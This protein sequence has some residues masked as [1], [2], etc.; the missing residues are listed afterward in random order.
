MKQ[1]TA[2]ETRHISIIGLVLIMLLPLLPTKAGNV[3]D[4][5]LPLAVRFCQSQMLSHPD[6]KTIDFNTKLKWNYTH[7]LLM[8]AIFATYDFYHS[9]TLDCSA[10]YHYAKGYYD[11]TIDDN[12]NIYNYKKS[13][14]SLDRVNAGKNLFRLYA[15]TQ[16]ERYMTAM[17]TLRDQLKDHPRT[18]DGGFWHKKNY[19]Y[20][21]WLDG[22]YMGAP[23][24]A[25]YAREFETNPAV[26]YAD[27]VKQFLLVAS[28]TYDERSGLYIHGWDEKRTQNWADPVTGKSRHV[29]GRA[30]GWYTRALVDVLEILPDTVTGRNS[31]QSILKGIFDVLPDYQDKESGCWF[32]V[33][34]YP[35]STD[36]YLEM[37]STAMFDYSIVKGVRLGYLDTSLLPIARK[38]Y[39]GMVKEYIEVESD[40]KI[41]LKNICA[42]AGL[43]SDRDGSYDYYVNKTDVRSNDP[44]G[45]GPFI[46]LCIEW[47]KLEKTDLCDKELEHL[48]SEN[49]E[50][51]NK[52]AELTTAITTISTENDSLQHKIDELEAIIA[53]LTAKNDS[54]QNRIEEL[55]ADQKT[56]EGDSSTSFINR[57]SDSDFTAHLSDNGENLIL[58]Y[59]LSQNADITI[60]LTSL[61]G[62]TKLQD[63]IPECTTGNHTKVLDT[64]ML[65]AGT[66]ILQ[67]KNDNKT[68][69]LK[70]IKK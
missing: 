51:K 31:M 12:G 67:V 63:F 32:Q 18:S 44:K 14:Y 70:Y 42:V 24:Y 23:Y 54:L 65:P 58:Y 61:N 37:S 9:D 48:R 64:D 34:D 29:W 28:H 41:T 66:Y 30:L 22:L 47:E 49:K 13:D 59:T 50:L 1:K 3:V 55:E 56:E 57:T 15:E 8:Q 35:D 68:I 69:T 52:V 10:L 46:L 53:T 45:V 40:G 27:V 7:G 17:K 62:V 25:Q 16:D 43:S 6:Y 60:T 11:A 26:S 4:E 2:Q 38:A 20:Q 36:N 33:T 19:P 39:D 21:M 5:N